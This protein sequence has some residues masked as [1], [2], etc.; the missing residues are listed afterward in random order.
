[1]RDTSVISILKTLSKSELKEFDKFIISPFFNN[2]PSLTRFYQELK[3]YHPDFSSEKLERKKVFG[4]L[5]PGK[6]YSD[7][8]IR[9][10]SS[11]LKK[12]LDDYIYYKAGEHSAAEARFLKAMEYVK[13][14]LVKEAEK[15]LSNIFKILNHSELMSNEYIKNRLDYEDRI[16]QLRLRENRQSEVSS[17]FMNEVE[18][19]IYFFTLRLSY[20]LHN[21]RVN[22]VI[23]NMRESKFINDFIASINFSEIDKLMAAN[24][25]SDNVNKA[26]RVYVLFILNNLYVENEDYYNELKE[27]LP[28]AINYF[29]EF[30]KYN[31]YQMAESICW[32]KMEIIDREKY[33]RELFDINRMR[34]NA[35]VF[36]PDGKYMRLLLYR[37]ILMTALQLKEIL[38]AEEFVNKY[39]AYLPEQIRSNL[40]QFANA[41]L[42]FEKKQFEASLE[43]L[44]K[45]DFDI[46][47]L[48]FDIRNL[49]LRIYLELNYTEE[50]L[51][52]IDSYKHFI[53]KNK[54]VSEYYK[55]I[56]ENFLKFCKNV[57]DLGT[58]KSRK[59]AESIKSELLNEN[60]INFKSWLINK[61]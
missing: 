34:L 47:T 58:G 57:I 1:M 37:Q 33:R 31:V 16:I 26:M 49:Q 24:K 10:L 21:I 45:I 20:Y 52:L 59:T 18:Y 41:H 56:T 17:N 12:I 6:P 29:Q 32:Q 60:N 35:G 53:S 48:K 15:E 5:Y 40:T 38:W 9:R 55:K 43:I 46:F 30:E 39:S 44:N 8:T 11:D 13:R 23:F 27:Y 50:A 7:E 54:N 51:S 2:Q 61:L 14:G 3:K 25:R 36:L 4:R 22:K 19:L 28:E 42:L